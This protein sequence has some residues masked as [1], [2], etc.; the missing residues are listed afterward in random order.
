MTAPIRIV[1]A[2]AHSVFR[3]SLRRRFLNQPDFVVVGEA[4]SGV[5]AIETVSSLNPD[6]LLLDFR[7]QDMS[8][9]DVLRRLGVQIRSKIIILTGHIRRSET[10]SALMLGAVGVI[11]K[12]AACDLFRAIPAVMS[13]EFWV[14]RDIIASLVEI[15][16]RPIAGVAN[17]MAF[18]GISQKELDVIKAVVQGLGNR[19]IADRLGLSPFTVKRYLTQILHKVGLRNRIELAELAAQHGIVGSV[20]RPDDGIESESPSHRFRLR[21]N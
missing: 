17:P 21:P 2:D 8:G 19:E 12:Q 16:P 6:L 15:A 5:D 7:L 20:E 3:E 18:Y 14:S 9:A 4:A 1:I 13:G 10:I 11:S